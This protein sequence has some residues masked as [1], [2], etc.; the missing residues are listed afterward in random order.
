MIP[1]QANSRIL[2]AVATRLSLLS[3]KMVMTLDKQA[4]TSAATI[5]LALDHYVKAGNIKSNDLI[6]LTALGGGLTWGGCLLRWL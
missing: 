6:M 1:H 4:N 5:G 2:D 3:N